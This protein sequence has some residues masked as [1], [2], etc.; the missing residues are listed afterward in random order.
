MSR[1]RDPCGPSDAAVAYDDSG[2]D[3]SWSASNLGNVG[4]YFSNLV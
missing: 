3:S 1:S 4:T 2:F